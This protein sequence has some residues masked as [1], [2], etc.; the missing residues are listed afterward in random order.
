MSGAL[1]S[2]L[3]ERAIEVAAEWHDATY[4]KGRWTDPC[5]EAADGTQARVPTM[6][7]VTTVAL[8]VQRA[9][10][11][12]EAVAAAFLHDALE[13]GDRDGNV[14]D[15]DRLAA[16]VG[17]TVVRIVEAVSEPKRGPD[18]RPLRWRARKETYLDRLGAGPSE[19]AAVSLADKLHNA[20]A[21]AS[22]LEAGVD[23]FTAAPGRRALSAGPD[24]QLWFF[25]AVLAA[26]GTHVDARLVPMRARLVVEVDRLRAVT[27]TRG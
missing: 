10:W 13:D 16:I 27:A 7:H 19:A 18:G 11:G 4:R 26:T 5:T 9:G 21:M 1:F 25:D 20:Y 17:E 3:V 24:D 2:P 22:S 6:A 15:R 12:D 23:I 8:T 14:L